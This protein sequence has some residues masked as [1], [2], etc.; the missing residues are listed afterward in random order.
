MFQLCWLFV[1]YFFQYR[2]PDEGIILL[3][4]SPFISPIFSEPPAQL[5]RFLQ[6]QERHGESPTDGGKANIILVLRTALVL[7]IAIP[8]RFLQS[9]VKASD[10]FPYSAKC[11][12]YECCP[13]EWH[14]NV[15]EQ[16]AHCTCPVAIGGD[17]SACPQFCSDRHAET[18]AEDKMGNTWRKDIRSFVR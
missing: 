10:I 15:L 14:H 18:Y 7:G 6:G 12:Q 11:G 17:S 9:L 13:Q 4:L 1:V 2:Y 5:G 8:H 3:Y 16:K